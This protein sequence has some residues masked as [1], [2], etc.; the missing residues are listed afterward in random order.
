MNA[1]LTW[2]I[3]YSLETSIIFVLYLVFAGSAMRLFW[4]YSRNV[5]FDLRCVKLIKMTGIALLLIN[6]LHLSCPAINTYILSN[7]LHHALKALFF[8]TNEATI[9]V[10]SLLL[11]GTSWVMEES[12]KIYDEQR[13][14]V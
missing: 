4:L 7:Q 6:I 9:L 11:I 8:G 1:P 2:K 13:H 10:I 5:I 3:V 14:T 12:Y